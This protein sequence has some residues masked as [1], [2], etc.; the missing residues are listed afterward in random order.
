MSRPHSSNPHGTVGRGSAASAAAKSPSPGKSNPN[1]DLSIGK[2]ERKVIKS[3]GR[4]RAPTYARDAGVS[5]EG[6]RGTL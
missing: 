6:E 4:A 2:E 3:P 1:L 5:V